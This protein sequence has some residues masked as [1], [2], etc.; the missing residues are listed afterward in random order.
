[1]ETENSKL[2]IQWALKIKAKMISALDGTIGEK[3]I[4][5]VTE[6]MR[7]IPMSVYKS[8]KVI[9]H[10][11]IDVRKYLGDAD[12]REHDAEY[13]K[14]FRRELNSYIADIDSL[15]SRLK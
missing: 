4:D 7:S 13:E 9:R 12:I 6:L 2:V 8:E 11:I 14:Y 10:S 1:M 3:G 5:S 15:I